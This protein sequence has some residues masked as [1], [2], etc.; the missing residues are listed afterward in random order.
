MG[1]SQSRPST[2]QDR[3]TSRTGIR[4]RLEPLRRFSTIGRRK[5]DRATSTNSP[6][7][8]GGHD[9]A[10]ITGLASTGTDPLISESTPVEGPT[11]SLQPTTSATSRALSSSPAPSI[12][13][14]VR[15]PPSPINSPIPV[16]RPSQSRSTNE[17]VIALRRTL[18]IPEWNT[19]VNVSRRRSWGPESEGGPSRSAAN[20]TP[21]ATVDTPATPSAVQA[22]TPSTD[23]L[24]TSPGSINTTTTS[25]AN[26]L[27]ST[28]PLPP[29][30]PPPTR[31][32]HRTRSEP[33]LGN[34][35]IPLSIPSPENQVHRLRVE[36]GFLGEEVAS[37]RQ[38]LEVSRREL[39]QAVTDAADAESN[40]RDL[41]NQG[42]AVMMIQG[43]AQTHIP[44]VSRRVLGRW[45]R[46]RER[47]VPF[48]EQASTIIGL[49]LY[50]FIW[51]C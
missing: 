28:N 36:Q 38:Q 26:T 35:L 4:R 27:T 18:H 29:R 51:Y 33:A 22:I 21:I 30:S 23:V 9:D 43:I 1:S 8:L 6:T 50:V 13:Y 15:R 45:R 20:V 39:A 49:I 14:P 19:S 32:L 25:S 16:R 3:S 7:P 17:R 42:G 11:T 10:S 46:E 24:L 31:A 2:S 41:E 5:R 34:S 47:R 48:E 40:L 37:L 44:I 12:H